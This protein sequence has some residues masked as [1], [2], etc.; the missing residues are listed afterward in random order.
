MTKKITWRIERKLKIKLDTL[1]FYIRFSGYFWGLYCRWQ[2]LQSHTF[3]LLPASITW[4]LRYCILIPS[5]FCMNACVC[6]STLYTTFTRPHTFI[7][8]VV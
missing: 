6:T 8:H 7:V 3:F 2:A 5:F 4:L 1:E